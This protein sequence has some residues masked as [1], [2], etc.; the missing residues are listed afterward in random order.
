MAKT[1]TVIHISTTIAN[2]GWVPSRSIRTSRICRS[3][4]VAI[5]TSAA[6]NA[7]QLTAGWSGPKA[8]LGR[9]K[10]RETRIVTVPAIA[11]H[12]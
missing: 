6:M 9:R 3:S 10:Y 11:P 2:A 12:R 1:S 4:S 5:S 8:V 7:S